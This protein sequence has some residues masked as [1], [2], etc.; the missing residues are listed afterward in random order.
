MSASPHLRPRTLILPPAPYVAAL[1]GGW[2]LDRQ[3]YALPLD[4]GVTTRPLGWL[5]VGVGVAL[6]AWTL[7][8]FVRHRTTVNPYKAAS[9][10]CTGGP[11]RF[12][13]NPIYLG[14]WFLLAG[15]SLL[16]HTAWPLLFAPLVWALLRYGV[17][18]HEEAHLEARFGD[19][20]RAYRAR[21][22]R[23]L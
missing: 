4:W 20:F 11:F 21:V 6:F 2:W 13:R 18:R 22:R 19:D 23:W 9:A 1:V 8:T 16:L 17:I 5:L 12:S 10:L 3:V 7:V 14:D 15:V